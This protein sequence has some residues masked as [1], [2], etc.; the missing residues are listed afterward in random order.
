MATRETP[1]AKAVEAVTTQREPRDICASAA[2]RSFLTEA[3]MVL[4]QTGQYCLLLPKK[5]EVTWDPSDF[6]L[7]D[8]IHLK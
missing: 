6:I 3:E 5:W 7:N 4:A 8:S 2:L 1:A